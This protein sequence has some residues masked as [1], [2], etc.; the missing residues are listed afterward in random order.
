MWMLDTVTMVKSSSSGSQDMMSKTARSLLCNLGYCQ[1]V[2]VN[3]DTEVPNLRQWEMISEPTLI[4][5][6]ADV[7]EYTLE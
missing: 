3:V 5:V 7:E 4:G 1:Q 6:T 2:G